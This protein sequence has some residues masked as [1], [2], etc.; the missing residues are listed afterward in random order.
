MKT[1]G[2]GRMDAKGHSSS[3]SGI[4]FFEFL[5]SHLKSFLN[6]IFFRIIENGQLV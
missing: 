3:S 4:F 5:S 6:L 1:I 2:Q